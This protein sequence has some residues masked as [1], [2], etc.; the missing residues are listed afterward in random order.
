M[1]LRAKKNQIPIQMFWLGK[2]QSK[3]SV[4][5]FPMERNSTEKAA[6]KSGVGWSEVTA[7]I[8]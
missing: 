2:F 3:F 7:T 6:R 4:E 1:D 5:K 8:H